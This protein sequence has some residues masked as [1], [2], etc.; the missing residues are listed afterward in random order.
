[1][2]NASR[3]GQAHEWSVHSVVVRVRDGPE[4]V[5]AAYQL[6][7]DV[8]SVSADGCASPVEELHDAGRDL[9]ACVDQA[10]RTWEATERGRGVI[11]RSMLPSAGATIC[12]PNG[13]RRLFE[14]V[15]VFAG[16]FTLAAA[17]TVCA[18]PEILTR[19]V[20]WLLRQLVSKSR[21]IADASVNGAIRPKFA[22]RFSG[23]LTSAMYAPAGVK[24]A[25]QMP[26]MSDPERATRYS[27][28]R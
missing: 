9:H 3:T 17:E 25:P 26:A 6:L 27:A 16:G 24:V 13:N 28:P 21:V 11:K 19:E 2:A 7:L 18:D 14:R 8:G 12:S 5:R 15:S 22:A 20:L 4:R 23:G 1:M 10:A